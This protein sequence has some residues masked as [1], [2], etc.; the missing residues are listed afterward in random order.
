MIQAQLRFLDVSQY[1]GPVCTIHGHGVVL[2]GAVQK[3][4]GSSNAQRAV[5]DATTKQ[6]QS[7]PSQKFSSRGPIY[8]QKVT[9]RWPCLNYPTFGA[10]PF[11]VVCSFAINSNKE[12]KSPRERYKDMEYNSFSLFL[13]AHDNDVGIGICGW[14]LTAFSWAIVIVTLPFSLCVCFKVNITKIC[15]LL[16]VLFD[17]FLKS[18]SG[19]EKQMKGECQ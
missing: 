6:E 18:S 7:L 16:L 12:K 4:G 14:L 11:A 8:G 10:A 19:F 17:I 13:V 5:C 15:L 2:C 9:I 3:H 1:S